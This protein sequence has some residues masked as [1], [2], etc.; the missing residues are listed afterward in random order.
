MTARSLESFLQSEHRRVDA[1]LHQSA[2]QALTFP[3]ASSRCRAADFLKLMPIQ[4]MKKLLLKEQ[5]SPGLLPLNSFIDAF[6]KACKGSRL[7]NA[8]LRRFA[9]E[10]RSNR[11]DLPQNAFFIDTKRMLNYLIQT[12]PSSRKN[13]IGL[14]YESKDASEDEDQVAKAGDL[15]EN[16]SHAAF[17]RT[18]EQIKRKRLGATKALRVFR[19]FSRGNP[20]RLQTREL[21]AALAALGIFPSR[22]ELR[23]LIHF[24]DAD[25]S[26]RIKP[27]A[28]VHL[29]TLPVNPQPRS[30]CKYELCHGVLVDLF[31]HN[32]K[33]LASLISSE[34]SRAFVKE[35]KRLE[36]RDVSKED[37]A[38]LLQ[39]RRFCADDVLRTVFH[40]LNV[41]MGN[42][43]RMGRRL[44]MADVEGEGRLSV[45]RFRSVLERSVGKGGGVKECVEWFE[46]DGW[47]D[48]EIFIR[49]QSRARVAEAIRKR[50]DDIFALQEKTSKGAVEVVK[51]FAKGVKQSE[52]S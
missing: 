21:P 39:G 20:A 13:S 4:R 42:S 38:L 25:A 5:S 2:L 52:V 15:H 9:A 34:T 16:P 36:M 46:K 7:S 6:R 47:V 31:R 35:L 22:H 19:S 27:E 17:N 24:I 29:F 8:E 51:R 37:I 45:T 49:A 40:S 18:V 10:F 23:S 44:E 43:S 1:Q 32:W 41:P 26:G 50:I 14:E 48:V 11:A 33:S 28:L 12:R 30:R 3:T